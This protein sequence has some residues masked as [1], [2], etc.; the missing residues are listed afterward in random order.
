[1]VDVSCVLVK[2]FRKIL[3][4]CQYAD[5]SLKDDSKKSL[6]RKIG[7]IRDPSHCGTTCLS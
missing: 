6:N 3:L 7:M 4:R 2:T 5:M 1:M